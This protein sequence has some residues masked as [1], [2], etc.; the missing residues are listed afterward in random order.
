MNAFGVLFLLINAVALF[1]M[2]RRWAALPLL[3]GAFYMTGAQQIA[4]GPFHFTVL[5]LLILVGVIRV[6]V[7]QERLAGGLCGLDRLVLLWGAWLLFT[8]GFYEPFG[9]ALVF[10]IGAIYNVFGVYFLIRVFFQTK[11]DV[12]QL[13]KIT[14][15]LLV[16]VAIEMLHEKLTSR[17]L[18]SLLGGVPE[19]VMLRDGRLRAQGPFAHPILAGTVGAV[20]VPLMIG[21]WRQHPRTAKIGLATC[22][23]MV[24]ASTSSG[25]IMTVAF[26][27]F[28]LI[29]WRWRR[30][31]RQMRLGAVLLYLFLNAVMKDP[32]YFLMARIDLTGSST[33]WHR[34][35][36][37]R[38]AFDKL[39]EWW[40]VG[41]DF[42][43]HWM[44]TGVS[45]NPDQA[46]ITNQYLYYGVWGGLPL[47]LLFIGI[48]LLA[49]RY[50][51][52]TLRMRV[53]APWEEQFMI[54]ALGAALFSQALTCLSVAYFDQSVLFLY[55]NLAAIA[56][57]RGAAIVT[58]RE[59]AA[60]NTIA[61]QDKITPLTE[62]EQY[63]G[64][65]GEGVCR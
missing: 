12:I 2:P 64:I 9:K 19:A 38:S 31:S 47:M 36:L 34:A 45:W 15:L 41:T 52:Q 56:S 30:Y 18:F 63:T 50:V 32:A 10:R 28:G 65:N 62:T 49:F 26:S 61:Y 37:I 24:L 59:E 22:L 48:L 46:D 51:G 29:L 13:I 27:V 42:T 25:P 58:A 35:E 39:D 7:R 23:G 60:S 16:P 53:D 20:C 33:G 3:L 40:W 55:L 44:P 8:S 6:N 11:A 54:W 1:V 5:R 17:N 57:L 43:R 14:A 4:I 21:I